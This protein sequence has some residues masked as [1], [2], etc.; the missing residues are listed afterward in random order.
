MF[1]LILTLLFLTLI[2]YS[3]TFEQVS[4]IIYNKCTS[5]HRPGESGPMNF[6]NYNEVASLGNMI[7]YVTQSGYM[8]P[9]PPDQ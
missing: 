1:R 2:S 6:T 4:G 7:E 9:W 8:P 5:C 3:Q